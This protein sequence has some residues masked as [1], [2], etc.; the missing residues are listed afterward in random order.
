MCKVWLN[1]TE[2]SLQVSFPPAFRNNAGCCWTD[3]VSRHRHHP[4]P[5][6]SQ[7]HHSTCKCALS[8]CPDTRASLHSRRF[9]GSCARLCCSQHWPHTA[10][11]WATCPGWH[12]ARPALPHHTGETLSVSFFPSPW[13][14]PSLSFHHSAR[15]PLLLHLYS[16]PQL[17]STLW[18]DALQPQR[19]NSSAAAPEEQIKHSDIWM[20]G[21]YAITLKAK[22]AFLWTVLH[23][24]TTSDVRCVAWEYE[25]LFAFILLA[26]L[27]CESTKKA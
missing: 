2:V 22:S 4:P 19:D 26:L 8:V 9:P 17:R 25:Q 13:E 24:S 12:T 5:A 21:Y 11:S 18:T 14:I 6:V 27:F 3:L 16:A 1:R 7:A 15:G 20:F 23:Q 10:S